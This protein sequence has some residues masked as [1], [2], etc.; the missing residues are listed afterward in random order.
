[1]IPRLEYSWVQD[2]SASQT[3]LPYF[4]SRD[5]ISEQNDL[6]FSLTNVFDRNRVTVVMDADGNPVL[7]ND[8][9]EFLRVRLEQGYDIDE[10]NRSIELSEY[11]RRPFSDFMAEIIVT[12]YNFVNLT[13]RTW[14]S[15][16][17]GEVTEHENILKLFYDE[18]A[19]F[20]LGYDYL[21][22]I[23]EYKRQQD[24]DMQIIS[25]GMKAKL[26]W[27]LRIGGKF[28]TDLNSDRDLEKTASVGW[29]H[30]C[31]SLDFI[32]SKTTVDERYGVNFNLIDM[33]GF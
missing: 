27:N 22:K 17:L 26:P 11:E 24:T 5:R 1:M 32:A 19:E 21:R 9:L 6:V 4:D 23:D 7:E 2:D 14:I 28:R 18:Y 16:Y 25:Y 8:Y 29:S 10:E 31:F 20:S 30:Q 3:K 15:P 12:P 33:S 13:S